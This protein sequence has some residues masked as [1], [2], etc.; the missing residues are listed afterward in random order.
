MTQQVCKPSTHKS[1]LTKPASSALAVAVTAALSSFAYA[2]E[3]RQLPVAE[4]TA[5]TEKSYKV[6]ESSSFKYTQPLLDTAKTITVIPQSVMKDRGV[7]SLRDALRNVSGISFAAGEGGQPTGDSMTIRGF[8]ARTDM[9]VDGIRDIA[10]YTRDMYNT[11]AVEVAKGPGSAV[12][13]R[14][15]TGGS[16]NLDTK[17]ATLENANDVYLRV[18]SEGDY[19]ATVD[20]NFKVGETT[21]LRVNAL[22]DDTD[23]AGR[24][25]VNNS[26]YGLALSL[27]T[28]LGT[29]SRF[30]LNA[31]INSQDN[32][33][34][35]GL[36]WVSNY[37]DREDRIIAPELAAD[38]GGAPSVPF[39]NFYGSVHR[40]YEEINANSITAKY[41]YDVSPSTLLRAQA[42]IGSVA[43]ESIINAPRFTYTEVDGVRI[44]GDGAQI[45]LGGEKTRDT[46][47]SLKVIQFDLV[48]EYQTGSVTH[49]VVA[50]V[51][52]SQER[53]ERWGLE[54]NGSD[55]LDT[56]PVLVSQYNPDPYAA[57][58]GTYQRDDSYQDATGDNVAIYVFDTITLNEQWELTAGLRSDKFESDYRI[59]DAEPIATDQSMLSWSVAAVY[60]P[61]AN[62]SIYF[63]VGN[64]F[65]PSAE[66]LTVSTRN[67]WAD[68][69][70]EENTSYELGTKWALLNNRLNLNAALFQTIKT[71]ARTDAEGDGSI[72]ALE[73][74]Q[75]VSGLE[76]SAAGQLSDQWA[77]MASYTF[78]D[79]KVTKALNDDALTEGEALARSPKN[80]FSLWSTYDFN[81][82][83]SAGVGAEFMD[84]RY[85]SSAPG[86][87]EK[88]DSYTTLEL[89]L[90]YQLTDQFR[91]QLNGTNL[92][93]EE[94]VDSLGGG[95]FIPGQ[96]RYIRLGGSYSF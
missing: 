11:E 35:Y 50:G 19:R 27:A 57:Y 28:G 62:G 92:T 66:G 15:S 91:L 74:E 73:G 42:R 44:Y 2:E 26:A 58:T 21:A 5:E 85:N 53:F 23:K 86:S 10:G 32:L 54:D 60:K 29:K 94:Y 17:T 80:S 37:S 47:D 41:E 38:E 34:D 20:S 33:P 51:E 22:L 14:G 25:E 46:D 55:N 45:S 64:S 18:G 88:A 67:N 8:S 7:E 30:V 40:D 3:L 87:R 96:G 76:L 31:D 12:N 4:A 78:Q 43:R 69:D 36:P 49:N 68:L 63:G 77:V 24:D 52:F 84:E 90:A 72:D 70:P 81:T 82:Q 59:D 48:G 39:S 79:G 6:D 71:N 75:E 9:F 61:V 56:T 13:G 93:D 1:S 89:M 95:H 65:N 16:I 83:W